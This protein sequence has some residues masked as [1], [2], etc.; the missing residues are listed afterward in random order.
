MNQE[1]TC[2]AN[3][4]ESGFEDLDNENNFAG[5]DSPETQENLE[6]PDSSKDEL[7]DI[8]MPS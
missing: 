4:I 6:S 3:G 8:N 7:D 2:L 5:S 1:S